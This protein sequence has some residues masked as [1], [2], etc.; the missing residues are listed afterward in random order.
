M[1]IDSYWSD[2]FICGDLFRDRQRWQERAAFVPIGFR[3]LKSPP[4]KL[5][6]IL[7]IYTRDLPYGRVFG[8]PLKTIEV[9]PARS[10]GGV[11]KVETESCKTSTQESPISTLGTN[12]ST[13]T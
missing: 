2:C 1:P 9:F 6:R 3:W 7:L 5:A 4:Q 11:P 12:Q 10:E 8:Q 13:D